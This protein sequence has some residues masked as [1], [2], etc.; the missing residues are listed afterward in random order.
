MEEAPPAAETEVK[1]EAEKAVTTTPSEEADGVAA[2][3]SS[4]K[5]TEEVRSCDATVVTLLGISWCQTVEQETY[6]AVAVCCK[7]L[8]MPDICKGAILWCYH[9][10]CTPLALLL[11]CQGDILWCYH[12]CYKHMA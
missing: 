8:A 10:H 6:H 9:V 2:A 12:A 11:T 5:E 3:D 1:A 7:R 4:V